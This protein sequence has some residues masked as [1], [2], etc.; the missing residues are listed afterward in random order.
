[1]GD[2]EAL[3]K[4]EPDL[5]RRAALRELARRAEAIDENCREAA[6]EVA[7]RDWPASRCCHALA[8]IC[9][10]IIRTTSHRVVRVMDCEAELGDDDKIRLTWHGPNKPFDLDHLAW[11]E[12][13]R[14]YASCRVCNRPFLEAS[15]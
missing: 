5:A 11:T 12:I 15:N 13:A 9:T 4:S 6:R 10:C 14:V 2:V 7:E 3:A 1:M 8:V